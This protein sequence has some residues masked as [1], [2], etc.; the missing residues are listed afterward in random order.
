M[1]LFRGGAGN[2]GLD[3]GWQASLQLCGQSLPEKADVDSQEEVE[4]VGE[5]SRPVA[6]GALGSHAC[7]PAAT[8]P[9]L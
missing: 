4:A 7:S 6:L 2:G 3:S 8:P 1:L 5:E 9:F